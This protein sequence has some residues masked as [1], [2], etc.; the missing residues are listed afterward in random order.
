MSYLLSAVAGPDISALIDRAW[1]TLRPGGV[2]LIHDFMLDDDDMGPALAACWFLAYLAYAT[3]N[4]SFSARDITDR[5]VRRGFVE[6]EAKPLIPGITK[7]VTGHK[8]H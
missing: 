6:T 8:P 3:D 1:Q 2:L 7:L 5:L 4:E